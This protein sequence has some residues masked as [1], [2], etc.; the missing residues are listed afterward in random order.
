METKAEKNMQQSRFGKSE[1]L[2]H[3]VCMGLE[4]PVKL[5][6]CLT[7]QKKT[8]WRSKKNLIRLLEVSN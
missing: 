7:M 5:Y 2:A 3:F 1:V 6:T 4:I 8:N